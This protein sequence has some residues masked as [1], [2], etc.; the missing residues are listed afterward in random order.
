MRLVIPVYNDWTSFQILLHDLDKAASTLPF[1]IFVSAIDDGSTEDA[2]LVLNDLSGIKHLVGVE[3]V[4]LA[5]NIG[6]Q[7]AIAVGLCLAAQDHDF[8]A[9]LI[10]DAD[11]E[12]PPHAIEALTRDIG[13]KKDYCF[14]AQRKKR[15]ETAS[16]KFFY[17][18]YK[19]FFKIITGKTISFGNFCVLSSSY[20]DRL[21]MISDLWNNL[22]AAIL[23]SRFPLTRIPIHRGRR[24]AGKSK[25]NFTSLV[26]HGLSG[27]SVYADTI[28]VRLLILS[29]VLVIASTILVA[30]LLTL[31]I[32]FP[33]HAT[34]GWTTTIAFGL[35]IIILQVLFTALSSILMLL[36]NRVQRLI[37]PKIDYLPYV[38]GRRLLFG[39]M[40]QPSSKRLA[41]NPND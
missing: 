25:M 17:L 20:V 23:R 15:V 21:V 11:G 13:D 40:H 14:V 16:F 8:D 39:N 7:R 35:T 19:T 31:R 2:N 37:L 41:P 36:N 6:H 10:M 30:G 12:D 34:P 9:L 5:V 38:H 24:Y 33:A 27:I 4:S 32:F 29:V 28:F 1:K 18:L 26:V 3:I 22:P